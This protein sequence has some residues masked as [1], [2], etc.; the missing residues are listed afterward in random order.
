M[1]EIIAAK[2]LIEKKIVKTQSDLE[3]MSEATY[4]GTSLPT[5]AERQPQKLLDQVTH[6]PFTRV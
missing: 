1:A 5:N 4:T 2:I 3:A 6:A